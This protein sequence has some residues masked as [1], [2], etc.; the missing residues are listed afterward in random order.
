M[1]SCHHHHNKPTPVPNNVDPNSITFTCPMHPEV[2]QQ[3]PGNCPICGMALEPQTVTIDD[4]E[5]PELT[6]FR[7][8]FWIGL[9]LTIPVFILE[10][11][12]HLFGLPKFISSSTSSWIQLIFATPVVLWAGGPFLRAVGPPSKTAN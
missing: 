11:G 1:T 3:G 4:T 2:V 12:S 8:R 9:L 7:R 10:M 5:N 6:D